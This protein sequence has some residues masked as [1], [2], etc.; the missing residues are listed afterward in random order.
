MQIHVVAVGRVRDAALRTACDEYAARIRRYL[1]L[2]IREVREAGRR[3]RD[4]ESGRRTEADALSAASPTGAL[5]IALT[6]SGR[7]LD[8][9]QMAHMLEGWQRDARDVVLMI[10]GAHGIS[11]NLLAEADARLSLSTMTLPHE[12]AR[13]V[14]LEQLYRACTILRGEPYHKG[15]TA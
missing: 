14:L 7:Q 10:G 1:K 6:R 8:S 2:D 9:E 5:R 12:L 13:L 15:A 3:D 11:T 4:A